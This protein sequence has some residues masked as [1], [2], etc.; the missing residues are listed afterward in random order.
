MGIFDETVEV[1][2]RTM[3]L[4]F[5]IDASGSMSGDKMGTVNNTMEGVVRELEDI[6]NDNADA[7]LKVAVMKFSSGSE[8]ITNEPVP[9]KDFSWNYLDAR[10]LTDLGDACSQLNEKLSR[11]AFMNEAAGSFAPAVFLMS[12]GEPTDNYQKGL[13][14]LKQNN[15]FKKAIKVSIAI[16]NDANETVLGEFAGNPEAVIRVNNAS[17]LRYWIRFV[18]VR[19]SE[20]GSKSANIGNNADDG[21]GNNIPSKQEDFI[22]EVKKEKVNLTKEPP[23]DDP[24]WGTDQW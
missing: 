10:G 7:E 3:V 2:R 20:I 13:E 11:N 17:E 9:A 12:D 18:S 15:W 4:F 8:W 22:E 21:T 24:A 14:L 5:L 23:K 16:G 6:S 1:A 19:A